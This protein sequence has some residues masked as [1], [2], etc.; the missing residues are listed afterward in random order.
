[1]DRNDP[2]AEPWY[3]QFWP[4][5]IIAVP[6]ATVVGCMVTIFL[7]ITRPDSLVVDDY[8][9]IEE[10]TARRF[11]MADTAQSLG[12]AGRLDVEAR[13]GAVEVHLQQSGSE[14]LVRWPDT[15]LLELSHPTVPDKDM[16]IVLTR[17]PMA[18]DGAYRARLAPMSQR[19][20]WYAAVESLGDAADGWRLTGEVS[21]RDG[22]GKLTPAGPRDD[23]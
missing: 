6:A 1:M 7:A 18:G 12:L 19:E 16:Q 8:S 13:A 20:R 4:W 2:A 9:R 15:L 5:F 10:T 14:R 21:Q 11:R 17:A 3:R 22:S 23:G